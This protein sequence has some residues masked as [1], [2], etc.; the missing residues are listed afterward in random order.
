MGTTWNTADD[1]I[2][3]P[4]DGVSPRDRAVLR[5]VAAGRRPDPLRHGLADRMTHPFTNSGG[6]S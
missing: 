3:D 1:A 5:A 2:E 6:Q 4:T